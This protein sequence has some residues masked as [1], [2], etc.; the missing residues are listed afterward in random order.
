MCG[1]VGIALKN[2]KGFYKK[3][4]DIFYEMLYADALRG[5]D[6]TGVVFVE[7]DGAFGIMKEASPSYYCS[8]NMKTSYI[9]KAMISHGRAMIGHNRKATIGKIQDETSHP[10][11]I[12]KK[13]AMVHNGTLQNHKK[14]ADTVV[15]SEALAIHLSTVLTGTPSKEAVE[16]AFGKVEGAYALVAFDQPSNKLFITRNSQRPLAFIETDEAVY[17]ASEWGMMSWIMTRNGIDVTKAKSYLADEN[18]LY[19]LDLEKGELSVMEFTPKKT[20]PVLTGVKTGKTT[21]PT[22]T[23]FT[24]RLSKQQFKA[25]KKRICY[26]TVSFWADDYVET[27]FPAKTLADGE[28]KL[29]L[30]GTILDDVLDGMH[31]VV[32]QIDLNDYS[33]I[34]ERNLLEQLYAGRIYE[35]TYNNRTKQATVYIDRVTLIP[36]TR[37]TLSLPA[38]V[39]DA[40]VI[41]MKL[42]EKDK[43]ETSA[44]L[45]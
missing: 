36:S 9:S 21:G 30:L 34:N 29:N 22:Q 37:K 39:I 14:L 2:D 24:D 23:V 17:W 27:H 35:M 20:Q 11:V 12:D 45:H 32:A 28:T 5:E 7:K 15:D 38:T 41:R 44:S 40:N 25:I 4:E 3:H 8:D 6:A 43:H 18:K 42:D 16:E 26:T 10:F 33:T 19:A 1:L 13:F 31:T